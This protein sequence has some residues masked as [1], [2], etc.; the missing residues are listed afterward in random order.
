VRNLLSLALIATIGCGSSSATTSPTSTELGTYILVALDGRSV[1]TTIAEGSTTAEVQSS[2]L[3]L[4]GGGT[5]RMLVT[6]RMSG[7]TAWST[8]DLSGRYTRQGSTMSFTYTNGGANSGSIAGDTITMMN[9]NVVW[10]FQR[11]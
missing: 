6:Y 3:T 10:T 2:S 11:R 9:E 5:V 7:Q 8:N 1:P 4:S